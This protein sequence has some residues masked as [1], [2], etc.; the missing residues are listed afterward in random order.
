VAGEAIGKVGLSFKKVFGE[1]APASMQA[2]GKQL[3]QSMGLSDKHIGGLGAS[4][5]SLEGAFKIA[6]VGAQILMSKLSLFALSAVSVIAA[7]GAVKNALKQPFV[8][9]A[10]GDVKGAWQNVRHAFGG[11]EMSA[12]AVRKM[13][14]GWDLLDAATGTGRPAGAQEQTAAEKV[15]DL[16]KDATADFVKSFQAGLGDSLKLLEGM[17][18][19][20]EDVKKSREQASKKLEQ[21][22]KQD[23]DDLA[24]FNE[25]NREWRQREQDLRLLAAE[26]EVAELE[27]Q[28]E[29]DRAQ[30]EAI[31]ALD[32]DSFEAASKFYREETARYQQRWND[33][34]SGRFGSAAGMTGAGAG[35]LNTLGSAAVGQ[36]KYAGPA[37]QGAAAGSSAGPWGAVIGA[38]AG[39]LTTAE[40]F[41]K[42]TESVDEFL[43][44]IVDILDSIAGPGNKI[45]LGFGKAIS[46]LLTFVEGI[47]DFA[48]ATDRIT[49]GIA[50]FVDTIS[51]AF[52]WFE[53]AGKAISDASK[54]V[55]GFLDEMMMG[56]KPGEG[57]PGEVAK[58]WSA[59]AGAVNDSRIEIENIDKQIELAKWQG[60]ENIIYDDLLMAKRMELS[61]LEQTNAA[62][63]E[64][65]NLEDPKL[66][67]DAVEAQ[68]SAI[69]LQQTWD[70]V[71]EAAEE[72]LGLRNENTEAI[73][74]STAT[75]DKF[76]E[77]ISNMPSGYK[78]KAAQFA[79]TDVYGSV[80]AGGTQSA[81]SAGGESSSR[82]AT[83]SVT[84]N[85]Y[86][87]DTTSVVEQVK[88][89][90]AR[91]RFISTG[92]VVPT[93][94]PFS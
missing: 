37:L 69:L 23:W 8:Q 30:R 92:S 72:E 53:V 2:F 77:A 39:L 38:V 48:V 85:V 18:A 83:K 27:G 68:K 29:R 14:P 74:K 26:E 66:F 40:S 80:Y 71:R 70:K 31:R 76:S 36:S 63:V 35:V 32:E 59:R 13:N 22:A 90:L 6:G 87:G 16:L 50:S 34:A 25:Q 44:K 20:A 58:N 79:A 11:E 84:I 54:G 75:I 28:Q 81:S 3:Q 94:N 45:T 55:A 21:Q 47:I 64:R 57:K 33:I 9:E 73:A 91:E 19:P 82:V 61:L 62:T 86:G 93:G 65:L 67:R 78:L 10:I 51:S 42:L 17:T 1:E 89:A 4:I 43:G 15:G 60:E 52:E 7:V 5:K 88:A 46:S 56:G 49:G 41:K 24:D 12:D